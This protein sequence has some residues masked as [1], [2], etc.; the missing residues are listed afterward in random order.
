MQNSELCKNVNRF[1]GKLLL[2]LQEFELNIPYQTERFDEVDKIDLE[3]SL[4]H[5]LEKLNEAMNK[6]VTDTSN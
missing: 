6:K 5:T 3:Q 4:Q 2:Q 1:F